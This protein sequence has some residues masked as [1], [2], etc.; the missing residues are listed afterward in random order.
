LEKL[1][2]AAG[3]LTHMPSH[4]YSRTGD[5]AG[6]VRVNLNAVAVDRKFLSGTKNPGVENAMLAV[7]NIHFLVFAHCMNGNFSA[8]K[9]AADDLVVHVQPYIK[10]MQMLEGFLPT[11]YLVLLAFERWHELLQTPAP[12]AS[13]TVTTA[14]WRFARTVA[15]AKLAKPDLAEQEKAEW[16]KAAN[17]VPPDTVIVELNTAGDVFKIHE[18]LFNAA[19]AESRH[20]DK[21]RIDFLKQAVAAQD[22]LNYSEPP[23]FY[24]PVRPLL[25]RAL[26]DAKQFQ[27]AEKVFRAA[28]EKNPRYNRAL[29]GLRDSL[30]GQ[31]RE[32]EA[33]LVDQQLR[34]IDS[35]AASAKHKR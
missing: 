10:E 28:L 16:R 33:V 3:H 25:G 11:P 32:G 9:A 29:A 24:P 20:D 7:H 31:G 4:I 34:E 6:S 2:P 19:I 18:N 30:K 23:A 12:D 26:L 5:Q 8:A 15:L 17:K 22:A 1:A 13:L 35:G 21:S 27:E 14:E